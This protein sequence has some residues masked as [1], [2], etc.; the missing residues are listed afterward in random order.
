MYLHSKVFL[1]VYNPVSFL[2]KQVTV[3][4]IKISHNIP[5]TRFEVEVPESKQGTGTTL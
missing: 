1:R 2:K 5:H 3:F 4:W